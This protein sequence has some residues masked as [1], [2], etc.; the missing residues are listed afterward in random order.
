MDS[1]TA[2]A[3][4]RWLLLMGAVPSVLFLVASIFLLHDS[5]SFLASQ[6]R[7]EEAKAVLESMRASNRVEHVSVDFKAASAE[8]VLSPRTSS[9]RVM[10]DPFLL[11][12]SG[13]FLFSTVVVIYSCFTLN[14]LFYGCLYAFPQVLTEVHMG[15]SPAMSLMIGAVW[16]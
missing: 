5:P 15:P 4:S 10:A 6:G 7:R 3:S 9:L 1:S 12:F 13:R 14:V 11:I 16:E 8:A 2:L